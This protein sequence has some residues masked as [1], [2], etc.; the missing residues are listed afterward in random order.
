MAVDDQHEIFRSLKGRC[1]G[2]Q[3]LSTLSTELIFDDIREMAL[4]YGRKCMGVAGLR[5]LVAKPGGLN[6][7][8]YHASSCRYSTV[9]RCQRLLRRW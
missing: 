6:V 9:A 1:H 7:G 8:L 5:R 3:F 4:A 2:D